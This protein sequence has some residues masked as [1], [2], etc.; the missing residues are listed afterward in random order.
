M[1]TLLSHDELR[2]DD[3]KSISPDLYREVFNKIKQPFILFKVEPEKAFCITNVNPAFEEYFNCSAREVLGEDIY[4]LEPFISDFGVKRLQHN[5]VK[6][7]AEKSEV[8]F[9]MAISLKRRRLHCHIVLLPIPSS[10]KK[11]THLLM[12]YESH[13]KLIKM[14]TEFIK[15]KVSSERQ[16]REKTETLILT[17]KYMR[18]RIKENKELKQQIFL[19]SKNFIS[20]LKSY[21][22]FLYVVDPATYEI[23]I[24]KTDLMNG[25]SLSFSETKCYQRLYGNSNPCSFCENE[26]NEKQKSLVDAI[27]HSEKIITQTIKWI[28]GRDVW[29]R[30]EIINVTSTGKGNQNNQ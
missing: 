26:N 17:N 15:N 22:G 10:E 16:I 28:D 25:N 12:V 30:R 19:I 18:E 8:I 14:E 21:P 5:L 1:T 29:L 23:L 20:L 3:V 7:L 9:D 13:N 4:C 24:M 2:A 11:I 27:N 6:T